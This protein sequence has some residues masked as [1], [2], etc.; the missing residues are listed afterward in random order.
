MRVYQ[1]S[2]KALITGISGQDGFLSAK[3]LLSLDFE[4]L[5][6]VRQLNERLVTL[7]KL[8]PK[9]SIFVSRY[10]YFSELNEQIFSFKPNLILHWA[11]PQPQEVATNE[12]L[13]HF[14]AESSLSAIYGAAKAVASS[15]SFV[16]IMVP[17]SSEI[18]CKDGL[19]KNI[20]S[21]TIRES[22]YARNKLLLRSIA[23]DLSEKYKLSTLFPILYSHES[24]LRK[25]HFLSHQ[26]C[27]FFLNF[28][29]TERYLRIG[30]LETMRD[31][32][33]AEEVV[34][35]IVH[36]TIQTQKYREIVVGH[37][38]LTSIE[39]LLNLFS[40]SVE[41]LDHYKSRLIIDQNHVAAEELVGSFADAEHPNTI[42]TTLSPREWVPRYLSQIGSI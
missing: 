35:I 31:W 10:D 25:K 26:L 24:P 38:K 7:E 9:L 34:G 20:Q 2:K 23:S 5:G 36:E 6:Y 42:L 11:A 39:E 21:R 29:E 3:L 19:P 17:G 40:E 12:K 28:K 33:W 32:S 37:G 22:P 27:D 8:H 15:Q 16:K 1:G 4:V 41:I 14:F 30:P 13:A 18:F